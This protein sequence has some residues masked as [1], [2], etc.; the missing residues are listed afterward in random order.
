VVPTDLSEAQKGDFAEIVETLPKCKVQH[1]YDLLLGFVVDLVNASNSNVEV[2][3]KN[4]HLLFMMSGKKQ[5]MGRGL[6][7]DLRKKSECQALLIEN[8][9][10]R[11]KKQREE[12]RVEIAEKESH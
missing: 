10:V 1:A 6:E 12:F 2:V 5:T 7:R 3:D 4:D 8:L 9:M 11:L